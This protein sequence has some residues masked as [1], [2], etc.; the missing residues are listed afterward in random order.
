MSYNS[1]LTELNPASLKHV[2]QVSQPCPGPRT[3]VRLFQRI[4]RHYLHMIVQ[5]ITALSEHA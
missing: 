2:S 1:H 4:E 5:V 3:F